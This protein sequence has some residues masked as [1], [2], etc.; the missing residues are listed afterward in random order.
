MTAAAH[1][2]AVRARARVARRALFLARAGEA[3]LLGLS[4][5]LAALVCVHAD[6]ARIDRW[7]SAA[8]AVLAGG[9]VATT[10]MIEHRR[11]PRE[12]AARLDRALGADGEFLTAWEVDGDERGGALAELLVE[13][14]A[15][16]VPGRVAARAGLPES[17]PM[18]I[19]PFVVGAVL[20]GVTAG[21]DPRDAARRQAHD[22]L[23]RD[24]DRL[25]TGE[26]AG[27]LDPADERRLRELA[28]E[29]RALADGARGADRAA[30]LAEELR[31]MEVR[32]PAASDVGARVGEMAGRL[33]AAEAAAADE[34]ADAVPDRRSTGGDGG[35]AGGRATPGDGGFASGSG[36][37]PL[38]PG[39]GDGTM[40]P[41]E[42]GPDGSARFPRGAETAWIG[43]G[44]LPP[45]LAR[46]LDDWDAVPPDDARR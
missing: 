22:R 43:P 28:R 9:L 26:G 45:D 7:G 42:T 10:W 8:A 38:A 20:A 29:A 6:G 21:E 18:L 34:R 23:A 16:A 2:G 44:D 1:A 11:S 39:E 24:L 13:R 17:W 12:V 36:D 5:A 27:A 25:A 14:A 3:F 19:A 46:I 40:V 41:R 35:D 30:A 32:L 4:T 15:R 33:A 31:A 37:G